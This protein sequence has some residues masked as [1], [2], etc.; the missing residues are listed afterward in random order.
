MS[1]NKRELALHKAAAKY[2]M[3]ESLNI[4]IKGKDAKIKCL[5]N[6]LEV[7]RL[8]KNKLDEGTDIN[9][10]ASLIDKKRN[11]SVEFENLT[12]IKWRL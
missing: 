5:S 1:L 10:I 2:I 3:G 9:G 11:L 8:L 12:G 7:S 4:K 6:L